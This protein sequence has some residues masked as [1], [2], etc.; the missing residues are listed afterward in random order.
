MNNF[1][2][3]FKMAADG[4]RKNKTLYFP[5]IFS[6]SFTLALL[7]IL[8]SVEYMIRTGEV[9]GASKMSSILCMCALLYRIVAVIFLFYVNS[10]LLKRRKKEFSI[11]RILGMEK[12]HI[13]I[14]LFFEVVLVCTFCTVIAV[15]SG[16][17]LSQLMF[18]VL[19]KIVHIPSEL[20][21]RIPF[22]SVIST[23]IFSVFVF[24]LVLLY[25]L[26]SVSKTSPAD[27]LRQSHEG[28]KE[29]KS[30]RILAFLSFFC[31]MGG[32]IT[33]WNIISPDEAFLLF[34]PAVLLVILGT[35][36]VMLTGS[37][38]L[39]KFLRKKES[40]FYRPSNFIAVSGMI[41]RMKQ[42]AAGLATI[43]ILSTAVL[44]TVSTCTSLFFGEESILRSRFIRD[45]SISSYFEEPV[46]PEWMN[47]IA[48]DY[49]AES[50]VEIENEVAFQRM[51]LTCVEKSKGQF[52]ISAW[53][54]RYEKT[55][56]FSCFVREDFEKITEY[57][58]SISDTENEVFFYTEDDTAQYDKIQ[59]DEWDFSLKKIELEQEWKR[60]LSNEYHGEKMI[61][62]FPNQEIFNQ[63]FNR[64]KDVRMAAGLHDLAYSYEIIQ[65]YDLSDYNSAY[66][67]NTL[68][69]YYL[70][71]CEHLATVD[72]LPAAREDFYQIY[73]SIFFA[74]LFFVAVFAIATVLI[75][76][77]KQ[78]TEGYEDKERFLIMQR[79]GM[80]DQEIKKAIHHQ[81]IL[82]FFLPLGMS[83]LHT[84]V[85]F[86]AL[87]QV[88]TLFKLKD[89][90]LFGI[91][92]CIAAVLFTFLYLFVYFLT[93]KTYYRIVKK[94]D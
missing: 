81:I 68:R 90:H 27:L 53:E 64:L 7:Y 87:C 35:F 69:D 23:V 12:H 47:Q 85:A 41:Y 42:N 46:S 55:E 13:R 73:G 89:F 61:L 29:P 56:R 17:L 43:C 5:Y 51:D 57:P 54:Q 77:Y 60:F 26:F 31:L 32:Y 1:F 76:Y 86:P 88:L 4:I 58:L 72:T 33:A 8:L 44:V 84:A 21:F 94:N 2:L 34:L 63:L 30:H 24:F 52:S 45:V 48:A 91:C 62:I 83:L 66:E 15:G 80:S 38:S 75:I 14:M 16:A 39:L 3:Y 67:I 18:L 6:C 11:Y 79:V 28:E 74:G 78:V 40:F 50:G 82:V 37:I 49:A 93:A 59:I 25:D 22:D 36:G 92:T 20:T 10:F 71:Y 70:N 19:L 65:F 9:R